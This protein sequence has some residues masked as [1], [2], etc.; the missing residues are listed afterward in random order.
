MRISHVN[1]LALCITLLVLTACSTE[2]MSLAPPVRAVGL[3]NNTNPDPNLPAQPI[4][5][6]VNPN[7][8]NGPHI[9]NDGGTPCPIPTG[10]PDLVAPSV[11][12]PSATAGKG[13]GQPSS[14]DQ[15]TGQ[16]AA[17]QASTEPNNTLGVSGTSTAASSLNST[18]TSLERT[19]QATAGST[20]AGSIAALS[21]IAVGVI[22]AAGI[23]LRRKL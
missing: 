14:S 18:S 8:L 10:L 12:T 7:D 20:N 6:N 9:N 21:S 4:N 11:T 5:P 16:K 15:Q 19:N 17:S 13:G 23:I 1:M 3:L 2:I 22:V